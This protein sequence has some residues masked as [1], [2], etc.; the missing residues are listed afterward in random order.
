M[1]EVKEK[2]RMR[3]VGYNIKQKRLLVF[4][5]LVALLASGCTYVDE[6]R[7]AAKAQADLILKA[8]ENNDPD[9]LVALFSE[10]ATNSCDLQTEAEELLDFIHGN[11]ISFE[12]VLELRHE[13]DLRTDDTGYERFHMRIDAI[14]TDTSEEYIVTYDYFVGDD[15]EHQ[16]NGINRIWIGDRAAYTVEDGYA[17]SGTQKM[18]VE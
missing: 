8:I 18:G 14:R 3:L 17:E 4:G 13:K 12:S 6:K 10:Y 1:L 2:E 9:G 16:R 5:L 15:P 11:V 7:E